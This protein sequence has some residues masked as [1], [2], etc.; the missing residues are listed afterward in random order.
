MTSGSLVFAFEVL[1]ACFLSKCF[2]DNRVPYKGLNYLFLT[3]PKT[4]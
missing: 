2:G 3:K 1:N 4:I